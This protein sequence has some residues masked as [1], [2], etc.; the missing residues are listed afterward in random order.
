MNLF[1]FIFFYG[2]PLLFGV[3]FVFRIIIDKSFRL[4]YSDP[5]TNR[6]LLW[7]SFG[8][9]CPIINFMFSYDIILKWLDKKTSNFLNKQWK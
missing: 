3:C 4:N 2:I 5:F 7:I 6:D 1:L 8:I 9:I